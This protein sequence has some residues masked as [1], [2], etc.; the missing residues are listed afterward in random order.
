MGHDALNYTVFEPDQQGA[1]LLPHRITMADRACA[2][3]GYVVH[4]TDCSLMHPK[5]HAGTWA[6]ACEQ[7]ADGAI[8][9]SRSHAG[10]YL[11]SV[12]GH[13]ESLGDRAHSSYPGQWVKVNL[14]G[15][16]DASSD[17]YIVPNDDPEMHAIVRQALRDR[18]HRDMVAGYVRPDVRAAVRVEARELTRAHAGIGRYG[19]EVAQ[20]AAQKLLIER[21]LEKIE[22]ERVAG[23]RFQ[24]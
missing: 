14:G 23:K 11:R 21:E 6:W 18:E 13:W 17:W 24:F 22:V 15:G 10:G 19:A 5:L 20:I 2:T 7:V 8:V 4:A 16:F 3:C 12:G 9:A 1:F